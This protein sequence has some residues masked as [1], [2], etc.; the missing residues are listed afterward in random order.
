MADPAELARQL[1][2]L[3]TSYIASLPGKLVD[4]QCACERAVRRAD[5]REAIATAHRQAHSL[6]GSGATFGCDRVSRTARTLEG[7]LKPL[8]TATSIDIVSVRHAMVTALEVLASAV[9]EVTTVA[10]PTP[11][12]M[13]PAIADPIPSV[14]GLIY[15][16]EDDTDLASEWAAQLQNFGFATRCCTTI[17]ALQAAL[18]ADPPSAILLDEYLPDGR[19]SDF[20]ARWRSA[21]HALPPLFIVSGDD[22]FATR[23]AAARAGAQAF[24]TKPLDIATAVERLSMAIHPGQMDAPQILMVEDNEV[25]AAYHAVL[26]RNAGMRVENV[27]DPLTL[28]QYIGANVPDLILMDMYMPG[29]NGLELAAVLRQQ[30]AYA[31]IPIVFLSSETDLGRQLEALDIG[32]DDFLTKPVE[33]RRLIAAVAARVKRARAVRALMTHDSL[34]GLLNHTS[35]KD[36]LERETAQARRAGTSLC[37]AMID[38]DHFKQVNDRHGH[39]AGDR[40]LKALAQLLQQRLRRS[41]VVGRYGGEEFIVVLPDTDMV[42]A[43]EILDRLRSAFGDIEYRAGAA[44]F[45][46][47]FSVGVANFPANAELPATLIMSADKALYVAKG[48]GRNR[49]ERASV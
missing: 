7:I 19:G 31:G 45:K 36:A 6:T 42:V 8:T 25:I 44:V 34:T 30:D 18:T 35:V 38:V 15:I 33:P 20:I 32:G 37:L 48:A 26:L 27:P 46:A 43:C 4:L 1:A 21:G 47:T 9:A 39:P 29:C 5:D 40:V 23:L 22:G 13:E 12:R 2:A 10:A 3:R 49:L 28:M 41:D 24:F 17:A 16:L 14:Q 11:I